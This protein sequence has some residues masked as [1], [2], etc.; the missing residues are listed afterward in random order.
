MLVR[1]A[2]PEQQNRLEQ[3]EQEAYQAT[4]CPQRIF[5]EDRKGQQVERDE[6]RGHGDN[7]LMYGLLIGFGSGKQDHG[8]IG[9][10]QHKQGEDHATAVKIPAKDE[11]KCEDNVGQGGDRLLQP[12][13][14]SLWTK[15]SDR[16][17]KNQ[18][19]REEKREERFPELT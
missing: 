13:R 8:S 17:E 14:E 2:E 12:H 10:C 3:D 5:F 4:R 1:K 7:R 16:K 18:P 9:Q 11:P 15:K 6:K 19:S